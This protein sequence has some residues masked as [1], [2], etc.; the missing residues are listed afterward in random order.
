M[1]FTPPIANTSN[2]NT[3]ANTALKM[4]RQSPF[5]R[6]SSAPETIELWNPF[7]GDYP[8]E[9]LLVVRRLNEETFDVVVPIKHHEEHRQ[10][11]G[12]LS[13]LLEKRRIYKGQE[14]AMDDEKDVD[15]P[16]LQRRQSRRT[17]NL[18]SGD[19]PTNVG[20]IKANT[21]VRSN[22]SVQT[23]MLTSASSITSFL[24]LGEDSSSYQHQPPQDL[25]I[26]RN[27]C[28]DINLSIKSTTSSKISTDSIFSVVN[29][30]EEEE[31]QE[32]PVGGGRRARRIFSKFLFRRGTNVSNSSSGNS[33]SSSNP[34]ISSEI[35]TSMIGCR[36]RGCKVAIGDVTSSAIPSVDKV[37]GSD[38]E[39]YQNDDNPRCTSINIRRRCSMEERREERSSH[40]GPNPFAFY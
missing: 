22:A 5:N 4:T 16:Q 17:S 26:N 30:Q 29:L 36:L 19:D 23:A 20:K 33:C 37:V 3:A 12:Q 32:L 31:E 35:G 25:P 27:C 18:N 34:Q 1:N 14:F 39:V 24:T 10:R 40:C 21:N 38:K 11:Q 2:E 8:L 6:R 13:E 7:L 15:R 28:T 9:D